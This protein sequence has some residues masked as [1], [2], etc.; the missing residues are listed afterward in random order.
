[1]L[2]FKMPY[3]PPH[4]NF[5]QPGSGNRMGRIRV[6]I[7]RS[8]LFVSFL[9]PLQSVKWSQTSFFFSW[10]SI[11][12]LTVWSWL[13]LLDFLET[14]FNNQKVCSFQ[15][16]T[17]RD[18]ADPASLSPSCPEVPWAQIGIMMADEHYFSKIK[19]DKLKIAFPF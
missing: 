19:H 15:S 9:L 17:E 8:L 16:G 7:L 1:M 6:K 11:L 10:L 18:S 2:Y 12:M 5:L 3:S 13:A 4:S 14:H